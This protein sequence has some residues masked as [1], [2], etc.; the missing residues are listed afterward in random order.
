MEDIDG[1]ANKSPIVKSF[2]LCEYKKESEYDGGRLIL[3]I[4]LSVKFEILFEQKHS[5]ATTMSS[6]GIYESQFLHIG[7][8]M[9][10]VRSELLKTKTTLCQLRLVLEEPAAKKEPVLH[11]IEEQ[12]EYQKLL[13]QRLD[14]HKA[15]YRSVHM[16]MV[17]D[18]EQ[19]G[20]AIHDLTLPYG[21]IHPNS[22][23]LQ[24][25][26]DTLVIPR[27][28]QNRYSSYRFWTEYLHVEEPIMMLGTDYYSAKELGV[29][30]S[31][32]DS[33]YHL[34]NKYLKE[35]TESLSADIQHIRA[36]LLSKI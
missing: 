18:L 36:Q 30:P 12:E 21:P 9:K 11:Q 26:G 8:R 6:F 2:V 25:D 1:T 28:N 7:A 27:D 22:Y 34:E 19:K 32:I 29:D 24:K 10:A 14:V 20:T 35:P 33:L 4:P 5:L 15:E 31:L 17:W 13:E 3:V 16:T 23:L